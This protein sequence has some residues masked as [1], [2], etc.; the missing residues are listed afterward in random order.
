MVERALDA[1]EVLKSKHNIDVRVVDMWTVK[2]IDSDA[3]LAAA[4]ILMQL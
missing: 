1:A 4:K 2:P 3:I